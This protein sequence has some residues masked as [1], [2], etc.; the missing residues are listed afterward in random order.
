MSKRRLSHVATLSKPLFGSITYPHGEYSVPKKR[1]GGSGIV[2]AK[3]LFFFGC[4][5][6]RSVDCSPH[7]TCRVLL[8]APVTAS[9]FEALIV[10][11]RSFVK[12]VLRQKAHLIFI[13]LYVAA[14]QFI[15]LPS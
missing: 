6:R 13:A 4:P 2:L 14:L 15:Y 8:V 3:C 5:P 10:K 1:L 11:Y 7:F 12:N 9:H